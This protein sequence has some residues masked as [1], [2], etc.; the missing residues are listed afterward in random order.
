MR[1]FTWLALIL[2]TTVACAVRD[3]MA[4]ERIQWD[5]FGTRI[6]E[7]GGFTWR[8]KNGGIFG[9]GANYFS[10]SPENIWVDEQGRLHL[11]ITKRGDR[12]YCPEIVLE[13]PLGYGDYLFKTV[14]RVDRL[15]S[16]LILGMFL[17][18]YQESYQSNDVYNGA[19]E[20]DIEFGTWKNPEG[21]PAQFACQPWHFPGN[22]HKF[23]I[24][25]EGEDAK[26]SHAFLW[27]PSGV[28]CR[29]WHGH[30]DHPDPSE[31][32]ETWFYAGRHLP[33][34]EAPRVHINYWCIEEPPSDG[35][36]HEVIIADFKFVPC[37]EPVREETPWWKF[38]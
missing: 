26:S 37:G 31:M 13:Q 3:P 38:W 22:E 35:Q 30:S 25:L 29:S 16:N 24:A 5:G 36:E 6:I 33:R 27:H 18:E 8:A 1:R 10:E 20:F 4:H 28:A 21:K 32:I 19:N 11:R 9:P 17:W 12:F 2:T 15:D 34:P 7:F 23:E 14:G